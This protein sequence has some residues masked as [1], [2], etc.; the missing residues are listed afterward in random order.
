VHRTRAVRRKPAAA[1]LLDTGLPEAV[2]RH[3]AGRSALLARAAAM[4]SWKR[5]KTT[6]FL[7]TEVSR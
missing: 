5:W 1:A 2:I 6:E 4:V 3:P 7:A